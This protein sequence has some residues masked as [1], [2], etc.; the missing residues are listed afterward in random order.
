MIAR[1]KKESIRAIYEIIF[2]AFA[3]NDDAEDDSEEG[4]KGGQ[5][6]NHIVGQL[7]IHSEA[8]P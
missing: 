3:L 7:N 5:L 2:L 6:I 8:G 4:A 1:N